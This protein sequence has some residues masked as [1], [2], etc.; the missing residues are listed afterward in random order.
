MKVLITDK[1]AEEAIQ[2]LKDAGHDVTYDEMDA[3]TLLAEIPKYDALMVRSRTK[4]T[5]EVVNAGAKGNLKVIGRAGIGVD[6]IDIE[7]AAKNGIKVV[8]SPTGST[9]SVAEL[10]IGQMLALVRFIPRGD[11]TMKQGEWI[12]KQLKGTELHGKT[13]GLIGSGYIAQHVAKIANCF[14]MKVLVYSPHC[15]DEKAKKMGATR[16][17]LKDLLK[18]SDFIS[19]HIPHNDSSHYILNKDT[20]SIMKKGAYIINSAR[21]GVVEEE[22]LYTALKEGKLSGAA[23]DVF[24]TEPPAKEN[25]LLSLNNVIV[26]PHI[27]ANTKEAQIQ[28]GTVCAEQMLKV[29]KGEDPDFW[30]NKKFM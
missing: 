27:G 16:K 28:A 10:A 18:E 14:G 2:V 19:L 20:I 29:L 21:G 4:A 9:K 25:K 15:T 6:N 12:K 22:A 24:E 5:S 23:V 1:M 7:T 11:S 13:L 26:T 17:N 3:K 8:N 30:V